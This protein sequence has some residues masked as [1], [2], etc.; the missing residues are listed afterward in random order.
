MKRLGSPDEIAEL[1][2][3]LV[4]DGSSY[5]AGQVIACDGGWIVNG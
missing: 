3:H 2:L 5:I 4:G 1:A